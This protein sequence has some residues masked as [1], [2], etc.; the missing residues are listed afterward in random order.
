MAYLVDFATQSFAANTALVWPTHQADDILVA[1]VTAD[2]GSGIALSATWGGNITGNATLLAQQ[3]STTSLATFITAG[4]ATGAAATCTINTA[5][6]THVH[7]FVLRDCDITTWVDTAAASSVNATATTVTTN[8][9]TTTTADCFLLYYLGIDAATTTVTQAH[10]RPGPADT[11]HFIDSSDNGLST[12]TTMAGA[13][14]GWYFKRAAGASPLPVWDLSNTEITIS[15]TLAFRNKAG[16]RIPAYVDDYSENG[17]QLMSGTWWASA[18][19]RNNQNFKATPLTYA[20][21][22]PNGAGQATAFSA[23]GVIVDGGVNP[24]SSALN[25]KPAASVTNMTGFECGF[26]T[27]AHDM[28]TGWIVGIFHAATSKMA[29]YNQ[30]SIKQ[31][32]TLLA[33]GQGANYRSFRVMGRDNQ[34]GN[35]KD[36]SIVSVQANQT[37][38]RYG[39]SATGPTISA[40]DKILILHRG[41]NATGAFY[42]TDFH[43]FKRLILAG[44]DTNYPLDSSGVAEV[45]RFCRIPVVRKLGASELTAYVPMQVGGGDAVNFFIDAGALQFPRIANETLKEINYHGED[46]AIGIS[47]A[48]KSGDTIKHTNSVITSP[49][50]YYWEINSAAT[51]A[52]IWDFAGL[53]IVGA[54]V[55]LRPVVTFT[56]MAFASCSSVTTTASTLTSCKFTNSKVVASSPANAAL[57]SAST[58]T[59]TAGTQH[60]LEIG[61]TAANC[62]LSNLTFAGYAG[63]DGSTG[64]EA[65]YVNIATGSMNLTISGGTTPSVRTAGCA[66]TVISGAVSVTAT[67]TTDAGAAISGARVMVKTAAGGPFPFDAAVTIVNSG[68]TATVTHTAHAMATNDKLVISGASLDANNGIFTIT[69]I[70][71]NSYSYTMGST[72]GSNPTGTIKCSFVILSG[73]TDGSGQITMNRV[74]PSAQPFSGWA[75][76]S[77]STPYYKQGAMSGTVSSTTGASPAAVLVSD[78]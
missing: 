44:G 57:I 55:T 11:M 52:A 49:S 51:N 29:L 36:F 3:N 68:T 78:D 65:V 74:F 35:G 62:T 34:D 76:K 46:G 73:T 40:I 17:R 27:T 9:I 50:P 18:V 67:V 42:Y 6:N 5:D 24:Y 43:L 53:V 69:K 58:F 75:R 64:N 16:G 12:T 70:D 21:V 41:N 25:S 31:G 77:T 8:A 22:G 15:A 39:Y 54:I 61:G 37:Q 59:K 28:T 48:G 47:Y 60:G 23:A 19:T 33:I 7:M 13:A 14:A 4:K 26:P 71:A 20:N 63:S 2:G 72:P 30:G 10:S 56:D 45:A 38:T 66:V 1:C 32:G